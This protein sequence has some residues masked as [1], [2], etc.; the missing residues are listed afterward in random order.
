MLLLLRYLFLWI[1][2]INDSETKRT[3]PESFEGNILFFQNVLCSRLQEI[4]TQKNPLLLEQ[5]HVIHLDVKRGK[6][7]MGK[8]RKERKS[9][10]FE[11]KKT[12]PAQELLEMLFAFYLV[13]AGD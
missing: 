8:K 3:Y 11:E 4:N 7:R 12:T 1:C 2:C 10:S 5:D 9:I 13:P 6:E